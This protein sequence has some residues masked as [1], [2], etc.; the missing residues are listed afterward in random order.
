MRGFLGILQPFVAE[1][2]HVEQWTI[3]LGCRFWVAVL[4]G[5]S[6]R[7]WDFCPG[8]HAVSVLV[9]FADAE[10]VDAPLVQRL[11]KFTLGC[12]AMLSFEQVLVP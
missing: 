4:D 3:L 12:A 10:Q 8:T 1:N 9:A 11:G 2:H 7:F 5:Y 6:V